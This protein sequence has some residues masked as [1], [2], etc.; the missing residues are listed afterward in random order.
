MLLR[1]LGWVTRTIHTTFTSDHAFGGEPILIKSSHFSDVARNGENSLFLQSKKGSYLPGKGGGYG[2]Q[3]KDLSRSGSSY[4]KGLENETDRNEPTRKSKRFLRGVSW[5]WMKRTREIGYM[6]LFS[7]I[8]ITW[9]NT[10]VNPTMSR[11]WEGDRLICLSKDEPK[12]LPVH[13]IEVFNPGK[14]FYLVQLPVL[15]SSP[16]AAPPKKQKG[17]L[18]EVELQLKKAEAAQRRRMQSEGCRGSLNCLRLRQSKKYSVQMKKQRDE[19]AQGKATKSETLASNTV[20]WV[21]SPSGTTVIFSEDIGLPPLFNLVPSS[22]GLSKQDPQQQQNFKDYGLLDGVSFN[23]QSPSILT[24]FDEITELGQ[25][26]YGVCED[27]DEAKKE[28]Q[29]PL[30]LSS[31]GLLTNYGNGLK[32]NHED[33]WRDVD[34]ISM[35]HHP[36]N[37]SFSELSDRETRDV[38]LAVLLLAAAEKIGYQQYESASRLLKQCDYMSSKPEI[39]FS[40]GLLFHPKKFVEEF[41]VT[42]FTG[43]QAIVENVAEAKKVHIIDL[44]IRHGVHWT[45][46]MQALASRQQECRLELLKITAVST[47]AKAIVEGTGKRLSSFAQSLGVPFAFKA[48]MVSDM[49]DLRED[50]IE[51]DAEE[52]IVAYASFAFRRMLVMPNR[53]ENIMRVLRVM[54][55]CLMVVTEIEA[56]HNSPIFVNHFIEVLFFFSA[57]FDCTATC[58]KQDKKN[59]EIVESVFFGEG[60]WNMIAAE[61]DERKVRHVK[62]DVWRAFF[63]WYGMEEAKLSMSSMYQVDLILKTIADGTSCSLH[64]NAK[65]LLIGWK[66]TP[67]HSISVWKFL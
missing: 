25:I 1:N 24:C 57:Y 39:R 66:G 19:F 2:V 11:S 48:V 30:C 61:G 23:N 42:Q 16:T 51:I 41:K 22:F 8:E 7:R 3:W 35:I 15:L 21:M 53:I 59:R 6:V 54:N 34:G 12:Q 4:G 60:I 65:T 27:I 36:F 29:Q 67:M 49:L 38:E 13:T 40:S 44:A 52:S 43:I 58:M 17:K 31:L 46:L 64:M 26:N 47:E 20:R 62:F 10:S 55:P 56:N 33:C 63:V 28:K 50:H 9:K 14:I 45:I 18:S 5:M 32:R 37:V